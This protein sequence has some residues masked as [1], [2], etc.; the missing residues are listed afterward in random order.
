MLIAMEIIFPDTIGN[1]PAT[2]ALC[3]RL[4]HGKLSARPRARR[5]AI[6]DPEWMIPVQIPELQDHV[7]L[8]SAAVYSIDIIAAASNKH[9]QKGA[10]APFFM[11]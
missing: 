4:T 8:Q 11:I 1:K 7:T 6:P 9:N 5:L 2:H 3:L 10:A